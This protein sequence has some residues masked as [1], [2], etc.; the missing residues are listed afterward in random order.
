MNSISASSVV[1][2][3][4]RGSAVRMRSVL[5]KITS[6]AFQYRKDIRTL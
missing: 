1:K 5:K 3:A 4:L 6:Q 2:H